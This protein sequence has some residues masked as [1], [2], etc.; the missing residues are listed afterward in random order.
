[1][2]ST[3]ISRFGT[4]GLKSVLG[5]VGL[6]GLLNL[7]GCSDGLPKLPTVPVQG[8]VTYKGQAVEGAEVAFISTSPDTGK[9]ANAVTDS[10]G[11]FELHTYLGGSKQA[12]GAIPDDYVVTIQKREG[13]VGGATD[14][15]SGMKA[16]MTTGDPTKNRGGQSLAPPKSVIPEK[17]S[18]AAKPELT[19]T[20]KPSGDNSFTFNLED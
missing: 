17:Y 2:T 10:Q 6:L 3:A 11:H 7:S 16:M 13:G 20:V 18:D 14:E 8:T 4:R 5:C 12:N 15:A 1:M 19:A 9:S